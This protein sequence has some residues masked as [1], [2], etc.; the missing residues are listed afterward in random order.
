VTISHGNKVKQ[1]TLY[2]PIKY[3]SELEHIPWL[4]D[5]N[6]NEEVIQPLLTIEHDMSLKKNTNEN[7]LNNFITNPYF[8]QYFGGNLH[9]FHN[10]LL[11]IF[12]GKIFRKLIL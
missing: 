9:I 12:L 5:P 4:D 10:L 3:A 1:I 6:T 7:I 8:T 2:P 11:I